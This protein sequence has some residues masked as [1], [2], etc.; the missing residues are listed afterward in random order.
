MNVAAAL[1]F[2]GAIGVRCGIVSFRAQPP[3]LKV[4]GD[5]DRT[6]QALRRRALAQASTSDEDVVVD[7]SELVFADASLMLDLMMLA[8]R[9]RKRGRQVLLRG[10]QPQIHALIEMVGVHRLPDVVVVP[11][12]TTA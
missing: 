11:A 8:Q 2:G 7:L 9:I 10:A 6:T 3:V 4:S 12:A 1:V 5:E